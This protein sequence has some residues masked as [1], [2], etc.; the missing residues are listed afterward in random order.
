MSDGGSVPVQQAKGD[1]RGGEA[2]SVNREAE[3][4]YA[5][6]RP[7][8]HVDEDRGGRGVGHAHGGLHAVLVTQVRFEKGHQQRRAREVVH[9]DDGRF[10][11]RSREQAQRQQCHQPKKATSQK[12][13]HLET[14]RFAL[15]LG[16]VGL[17][18]S[19]PG[20]KVVCCGAVALSRGQAITPLESVGR[21]LLALNTTTRDCE[22]AGSVGGLEPA[23]GTVVFRTMPTKPIFSGGNCIVALFIAT[24]C[25]ATGAKSSGGGAG[26]VTVGGGGRTVA[27]PE[28]SKKVMPSLPSGKYCGSHRPHEEGIG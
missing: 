11:T 22:A 20:T 19:M 16:H 18:Y 15:S 17:H 3:A 5:V 9:G 10:R 6:G 4:R 27:F 12:G 1:I 21:I 13:D 28:R 23:A 24:F 25:V 8:G 7:L 2:R 26:S 14:D